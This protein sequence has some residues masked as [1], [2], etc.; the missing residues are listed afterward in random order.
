MISP[1]PLVI[2][3]SL[4][5]TG[6]EK[7]GGPEKQEVG[8]EMVQIQPGEATRWLEADVAGQEHLLWLLYDGEHQLIYRFECKHE[9]TVNRD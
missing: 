7:Q 1:E 6:L 3:S 2:A 5:Q 4:E 9:Q 8:Q